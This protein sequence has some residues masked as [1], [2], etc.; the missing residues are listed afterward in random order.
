MTL[1]TLQQFADLHNVSIQ[2]VRAK[3]FKT[4]EKFGIKLIDNK[5]KYTP[6]RG[7]GRKPVKKKGAKK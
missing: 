2:A 7:R 4:V 1:I 6:I 3:G 5:T